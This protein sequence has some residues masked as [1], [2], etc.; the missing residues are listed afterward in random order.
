MSPAAHNT[1]EVA[2]L[3]R[4]VNALAFVSGTNNSTEAQ[5]RRNQ[6]RS[7]CVAIATD[8]DK[9]RS[10]LSQYLSPA[11]LE[12]VLTQVR[13]SKLSVKGRR[14]THS[15]KSLIYIS[16]IAQ[17]IQINAAT[18]QNAICTDCH[19]YNE[20]PGNCANMMHLFEIKASSM[21]L[22]QKACAILLDEMAIKASV[23][24]NLL[25]DQVE[26]FEDFGQF[27][28]SPKHTTSV[29][30]SHMAQ[31]NELDCT[32]P[33]RMAPKLS[34][35]HMAMP[36]FSH[37]RDCL[38][39]QVLSHSV[40]AGV[41]AMVTLEALPWSLWRLCHGHSGGS[42]MVSLEALPWSLWRLCDGHSGC[43]AISGNRNS[44]VN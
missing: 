34:S 24:Y 35:K 33:I 2:I 4:K 10:T 5:Q 19:Q 28:R 38:T 17:G 27:G 21:A 13:V 30:C 7:D 29:L 43:S 16:C 39:A 6:P 44:K 32:S 41:S 11:A 31:F 25:D 22:Q 14:W 42:A 8:A 36:P 15:D 1:N 9:L 40:A 37:L 12:F 20:K 3:K 26:G 18:F 23:Q